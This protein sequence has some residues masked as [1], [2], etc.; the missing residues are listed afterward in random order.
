MTGREE[1]ERFVAAITRAYPNE[2]EAV[3]LN[4]VKQII[5][6]GR[7]SARFAEHACNRG[8]TPAEERRDERNDERIKALCESLHPRIKPIIGGDPR[9]YTVKLLLPTEEYNTWGGK[10]S[11]WGVPGS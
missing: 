2:R 8:L 3:I 1:R 11:G 7:T 9:G 4:F 6:L 10:E 5:R